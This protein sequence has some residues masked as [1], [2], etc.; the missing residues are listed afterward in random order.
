MKKILYEIKTD[1][2]GKIVIVNKSTGKV[3]MM[4]KTLKEAEQALNNSKWFQ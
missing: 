3:W 4:F 2:F 1:L